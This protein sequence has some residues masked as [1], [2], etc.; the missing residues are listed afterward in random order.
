MQLLQSISFF[1]ACAAGTS[2]YP[3]Q[4][5][6][7]PEWRMQSSALAQGNL[8]QL[9]LPG[10]D[11]SSWY[12]VSSR[13]TVMAGLIENGVYNDSDL[14]YSNNMNLLAGDP[15][16]KVPWLYRFEFTA[17]VDGGNHFTLKTHGITSKADIYVNGEIVVASDKQQGSYGGHKYPLTKYLNKEATAINCI[18]IRA[19]PT[20]YRRDFA[21]GFADWNPYPADNGMGM[22]R[23]VEIAQTGA[24]TMSPIRVVTNVV[25]HLSFNP[26]L[27]DSVKVTL[28]T[29]LVNHE[30]RTIQASISGTILDP[31]GSESTVFSGNFELN[32]HETRTVSVEVD[33]KKPE[34]WW[35]VSWGK[36][37]LYKAH[38]KVLF[39]GLVMSD[40]Y[41]QRFGIRHVSSG[42]N[43]HN[44]TAFW[45]NGHPFQVR[46]AG[47]SPDIF[48]RFD[49]NRLRNIFY[50]MRDMGLNTVRLEGKQE[51]PELYAIADEMGI[52]VLTGWECCDKWEGWEYNHDAD[53]VK[54]NGSDY[55]V[56]RAAMLH[57]AEMMQPHPSILG[58]LVGSD[59][60][61]NDQVTKV[62]LDAIKEMEFH[63]PIIASASMRGP[64][65]LGPSGLGPSGMKMVGPYDW[66][67]PNYWYGESEG[68]A[69]G[70]GSELGAGVGT[71][72][73]YSLKK[74]MSDG[75]LDS[76]WKEPTVGQY[77]MSSNTSSF[78]NRTIYNEA[79]F[80]R[81]GEPTSIEDY[82]IKCQMADYEATR[83]QFEAY[84]IRQ[85]AARPATGTIY[86]M[87]NSAWPNLHWQLFDKYLSPM[88][89]YFGTKVGARM[90]HVAFDPETE[91][92]WSINHSLEKGGNREILIDLIDTTG[93]KISSEKVAVETTP[94]F[95]KKVHTLTGMGKI[96]D[97][98]F[99]R[100]VLR[101]ATG[102][103]VMSR[104]VYW[105][106]PKPDELDWERTNWYYT[107]VSQFANFQK[108]NSLTEAEVKQS[109]AWHMTTTSGHTGLQI[110]LENKSKFPA[111]F[112][113]LYL[114]SKDGVEA[115]PV[116]W[117][118]NY[119]TL[120]PMEKLTI[121]AQFKGDMSSTKLGIS[122]Y[123]L[124][125]QI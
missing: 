89:S 20:E 86:W 79:L 118:D 66:V 43:E 85:N 103:N 119:V 72:E 19:H 16:F 54:W 44:D 57:E 4:T 68:A 2:A 36:Q 113:H 101:D 7:I 29:V 35:P 94:K 81:Y 110:L 95:S 115:V 96:N 22:W 24:V 61:P 64:S 55:S 26:Y 78:H 30:K 14:F 92:V 76:L 13:S 11:I 33:I 102:E 60:W 52:M 83:A 51:H 37:P 56:A 116:F 9:S 99:L 120:W 121:M 5:S 106:S 3:G 40:Q 46:G 125:P 124:K 111:V 67:P 59:Y 49:E 122:G 109:I 12:K 69:F 73:L 112:L 65:K 21:I 93:K 82:V 90:E 28:K 45:V 34:I 25:P 6:V 98:A 80:A 75:D 97:V 87:L 15:K 70:F 77:H 10:T 41:T 23:D 108:L 84:S 100:L 1:V 74:F 8:S 42:M 105:L 107:P 50:Y 39:D 47:Y 91:S 32:S 123:N 114:T 38:A 58:F 71:P 17:N 88:G 62:Y 48:L 53:A 104:N 18:L 31:A 63:V 117:S 27:N